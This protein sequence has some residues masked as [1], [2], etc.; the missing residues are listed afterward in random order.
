MSREERE[1]PKNV[2]EWRS[3]RALERSSQLNLW[4]RIIQNVISVVIPA[5]AWWWIIFYYS[6]AYLVEPEKST[7]LKIR[8]AHIA[9]WMTLGFIVWYVVWKLWGIEITE[10]LLTII[11]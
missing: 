6:A 5:L 8:G 9:G 3:A 7:E 4:L 10:S 1:G 2:E 11:I